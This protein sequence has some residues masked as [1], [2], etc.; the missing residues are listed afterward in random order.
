M[1][2]DFQLLML[3]RLSFLFFIFTMCFS[4]FI[5]LCSLAILKN[6]LKD[7]SELQNMKKVHH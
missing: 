5:I 3:A 2:I 6:D 4:V 7:S 1:S